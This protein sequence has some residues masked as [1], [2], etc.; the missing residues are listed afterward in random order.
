MKNFL[1]SCFVEL[2]KAMDVLEKAKDVDFWRGGTEK[3]AFW[4][5]CETK[6]PNVTPNP[7]SNDSDSSAVPHSSDEYERRPYRETDL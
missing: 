7:T 4:F 6:V 1:F 2:T 3:Y 5:P